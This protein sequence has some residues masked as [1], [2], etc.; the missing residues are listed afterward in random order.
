MLIGFTGAQCTGKTTLLN[1]CKN[2]LSNYNFVDEVTRKVGRMGRVINE[3]GDD[4]TQL[5]I[6]KEHLVNHVIPDDE[7]WILD[8]CIVDGYVYT[9]WLFE[10]GRVSGWVLNHAGCLLSMLGERLDHILYTCP[11]NIPMEDDGGRSI[12][13]QFRDEIIDI[14]EKLFNSTMLVPGVD[15]WKHKVI[16]LS[17]TP[18]QRMNQITTLINNEQ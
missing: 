6:L 15:T 4:L 14:Y 11:D 1:M 7:N 3:Q 9:R 16:K 2:T 18:E 12:N 17:G 5:F 8:R 10:Q 13:K